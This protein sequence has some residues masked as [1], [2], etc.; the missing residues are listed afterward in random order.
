MIGTLARRELFRMV[1]TPASWILLA[2]LQFL[3]AYLFLGQVEWYLSVAG[4]LAIR[5][6]PPGVTDL[7]LAPYL[8]N[9][10]TL[11]LAGIP[12]LTMP[13]LSEEYRT[14]TIRLLLS[15]PL[16]STQIILGKYLGSLLF[17]LLLLPL[18][19]LPAVALASGTTLDWGQALGGLIGLG[20]LCCSLTALGL[21]FSTL[22]RSPPLAA[23]SSFGT[24]L[25]LWVIQPTDTGSGAD[26]LLTYLAL[27][28]HVT[29][30]TRGLLNSGD[31]L[32]H[33]L[34]T[35]V[36]LSLAVLRLDQERRLH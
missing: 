10:A 5:P 1:R 24:A 9:T 14:G 11:L 35:V 20:L 15:A 26:G 6:N 29:P 22:T 25:L 4:E 16:S 18:I 8:G 28:E 27:P 17:L 7:V 30:F 34:L 31:L 21:L 12:L 19:M 33:L 36:A 23:T 2:L 13:L 32:Y 3:L